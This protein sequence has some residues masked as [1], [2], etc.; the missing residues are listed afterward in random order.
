M[1]SHLLL[2]SLGSNLGDRLVNLKKAISQLDR[3]LGTLLSVSPVYESEPV[4][5][6]DHPPY[7]N[8]VAAF[9]TQLLPEDVLLITQKEEKKAGRVSKGDLYPRQLDIDIL[10]FGNSVFQ[11]E[12][13]TIPH[14]RMVNRLFVLVPLMDVCPFFI[15][16]TSGHTVFEMIENCKDNAWVRKLAWINSEE[17]D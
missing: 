4:G 13:L 1:S 2:L 6:Q 15:N 16:P 7:L 11:E 8:L 5:V 17:L 10:A 12:K 3:Q 9:L 14:P